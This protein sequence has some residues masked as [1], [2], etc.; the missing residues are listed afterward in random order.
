M[1]KDYNASVK[2]T[3]IAVILTCTVLVLG[4][5]I[6]ALATYLGSRGIEPED[7]IR[8][9]IESGE[10]SGDTV[11]AQLKDF[12]IRGF[13]AQKLK[14]IEQYFDAYYYKELPSV[15]ELAR[16][17][18]LMFLDYYYDEI[19]LND[20]TAVTDAICTCY[21]T[22]I[23]DPYAYY[24][25]EEEYSD[26]LSDMSGDE[27]SVGIGVYVELDYVKNT[28]KVTSVFPD[29]AAEEAGILPGD[30][31]IGVDGQ[32]AE[33]VGVNEM[34]ALIAGEVGTEVS[35][36]VKRGDDVLT[37]VATRRELSDVTVLYELDENKIGYIL[38]SQFKENTPEQFYEAIDYMTENGAVGIVFDMRNNPGGLL[39]AVVAMI[40]YIAPDGNRIA[41][42]QIGTDSKTVF[43][44]ED[45]HSVNLPIA[46]LCN[47]N[48][49]SAGELFT[50]AMRD[51]GKSGVLN[52]VIVGET[53]YKKGI[54]QSSFSLFDGSAIK[55]TIA[56]YNPPS[57]V[58]YDGFGVEPDVRITNDGET[59]DQLN[60]AKEAIIN[61]IKDASVAM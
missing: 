32:L 52:T 5:C 40:D 49:A 48:T 29:S 38:V 45:G 12:G 54:M 61:M 41:S 4:I 18:A 15:S 11:T 36:T 60:A 19:D 14:L 53:T 33:D 43:T 42:Y 51:Y 50:A 9:A 22:V 6:F 2:R 35:L 8:A 27:S 59:D 7:E 56:F 44:A 25:T 58:N 30:Y 13:Q 17:T 23:G 26:Y 39:D 10:S 47:G 3:R 28:V 20:N 21:V 24:F 31:I 55:L 46:V 34:T 16:D 57:D 1:T 37:I